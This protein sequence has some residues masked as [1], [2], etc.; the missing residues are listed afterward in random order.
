[1]ISAGFRKNYVKVNRRT[2]S[3]AKYLLAQK[4]RLFT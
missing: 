1:M 4:A 3:W 2:I